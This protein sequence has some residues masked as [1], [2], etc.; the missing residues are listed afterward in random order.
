MLLN[1]QAFFIDK[2]STDYCFLCW[3]FIHWS[4][5]TAE[6]WMKSFYE[7]LWKFQTW[8]K[9]CHHAMWTSC[10]NC[11]N[12]IKITASNDVLEYKFTQTWQIT[13]S[14]SINNFKVRFELSAHGKIKRSSKMR[15]KKNHQVWTREVKEVKRKNWI[16]SVTLRNETINFKHTRMF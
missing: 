2:V 5:W 11:S 9:I 6:I 10:F 7:N 8:Q 4:N 13:S 15:W 16:S 3:E 1:V 12:A 14:F